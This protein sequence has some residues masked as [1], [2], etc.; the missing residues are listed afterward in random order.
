MVYILPVICVVPHLGVRPVDGVAQ[1]EHTLE[2]GRPVRGESLDRRGQLARHLC[3]G[4]TGAVA[5]AFTR[6]LML[7]LNWNGFT[8]KFGAGWS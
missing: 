4:T 5:G 3:G 2:L 6:V 8:L 7:Q 1:H